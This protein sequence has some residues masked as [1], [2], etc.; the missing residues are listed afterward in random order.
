MSLTQTSK[1]FAPNNLFPKGG[2]QM[3]YE[4]KSSREDIPDHT[5]GSFPADSDEE[6]RKVFYRDYVGNPNNS[7]DHLKLV[8]VVQKR[9]EEIIEISDPY[10]RQK[11]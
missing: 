8:K 5:I 7:W 4:V 10:D 3:D 1:W 2:I 6:A 11:R 9:V